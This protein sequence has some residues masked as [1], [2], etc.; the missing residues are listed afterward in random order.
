MD[1]RNPRYDGVRGRIHD[2]V[3]REYLPA[4]DAKLAARVGKRMAYAI[5]RVGYKVK[6]AVGLYPT[7]GA[8]DDYAYSR[9]LLDRQKGK[10]IAFTVEWGRSRS[11]RPFHPPYD[12]MRKVMREVTAGLLELCLNVGRWT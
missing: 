3:Y 11:S 1:F 7:A 9:H 6:Q 12:E 4:G 5:W 10:F 2:Q 8:S